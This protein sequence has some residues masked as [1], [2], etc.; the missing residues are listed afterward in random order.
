MSAIASIT[1]LQLDA[2]YDPIWDPRAA[3]SDLAAVEQAIKTT[4]LLFQGEW[5]ESLNVG[6]PMFQTILGKRTTPNGLQIMSQALSARIISVPYVSAV[7]NVV[8]NFNPTTRH[9]S[10]SATAQT[11][12]GIANVSFA[13]GESAGTNG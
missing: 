11:A 3:L 1:Y 2:E 5:W 4:I 10:F 8:V 9:F 13:P 7:Q 6:T 12:F